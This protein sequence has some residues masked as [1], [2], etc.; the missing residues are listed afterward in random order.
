MCKNWPSIAILNS[1]HLLHHTV[2]HP[3]KFQADSWNP[4][5]VKGAMSSLRP[6][7]SLFWEFES[8]V[9]RAKIGQ[10]WP[11]YIAIC[12]MLLCTIPPNFRQIAEILQELERYCRPSDLAQAYHGKFQ[13]S[14]KRAKIGQ[15]W[16]LW[17]AICFMLLC[18]IAPNF[19]L[20]TEIL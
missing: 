16:P 14:T 1:N 2:H 8:S 19:R 15:A 3:T 17:L 7:P 13:S 10:A 12:F 11:F 20:I 5:R 6:G 18:T 4:W 9:E